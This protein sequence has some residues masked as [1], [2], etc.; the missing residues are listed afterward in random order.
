MRKFF[1]LP[2]SAAQI[3]AEAITCEHQTGRSTRSAFFSI[4][5][6][7]FAR[8]RAA[9]QR[10]ESL[11]FGRARHE[12]LPPADIARRIFDEFYADRADSENARMDSHRE[13]PG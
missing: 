10:Y 9:V 11:R 4:L 13:R 8:A 12:N 1:D 7:E 3:P 6:T 2:Q 5:R